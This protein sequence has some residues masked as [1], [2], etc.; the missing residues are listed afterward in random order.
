MSTLVLV[1]AA[2]MAIPGDI[3]EKVSAEIEQGLVR[4]SAADHQSYFGLLS[5]CI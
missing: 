4:R 1:L 5:D 3:P 2:G